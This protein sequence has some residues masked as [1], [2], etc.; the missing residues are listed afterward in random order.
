MRWKYALLWSS[1]GKS[2]IPLPNHTPTVDD[3]QNKEMHH[4]SSK[5]EN[6]PA[7]YSSKPFFVEKFSYLVFLQALTVAGLQL[8]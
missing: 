5:V 3:H 4:P 2:F 8:G 1:K 6:L 7:E